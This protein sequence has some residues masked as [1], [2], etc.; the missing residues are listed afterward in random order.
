MMEDAVRIIMAVA[1]IAA[2]ST[3][4]RAEPAEDRR[5]CL[6]RE[7]VSADQKLTACTALI[8]ARRETPQGLVAAF[9]NR[10]IAY[11]NKRDYDGAIRDYDQILRLEPGNAVAFNNRGNSFHAKALFDR[12]VQD[13]DQAIRLN[14]KYA[15]AF[16]N[17]AV[18]HRSKSRFDDAIQDCSQAIAFNPNLVSAYFGRA[19]AYQEKARWDFD[20]YLSEGRYDDLAILDLDQAIRLD[21]KSAPAFANRGNIFARKRQYERAIADYSEAVRLAPDDWMTFKNRAL[22]LR[23]VGQYDRA[24]ADYRKA[25]TLNVDEA[26][27]KQVETALKQLRAAS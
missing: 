16:V 21:S 15:L 9:N 17:R 23:Y 5:L 8:E 20:A 18:V 26:T 4:A 11:H 27:R 12:A 25:L 2:L 1:L 24:I 22:A 7:G 13:Y 6:A 10:G 3:A 19:L 14:P